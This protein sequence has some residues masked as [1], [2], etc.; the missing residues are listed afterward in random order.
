MRKRLILAVAA[1]ALLAAG[2]AQAHVTL[3]PREAPADSF[4]RLNV[5]VPNE[6]DR[7]STEKV[8]LQFPPGFLAISYE[9]VDGWEIDVKTRKLDQPAELFGERVTEEVDEVSLTAQDGE[10]IRPG[11]FRDFGLSLRIPDTPNRT[12]TFKALQTYS[13]GE[14][15]RWIGPPDSDEPAPQVRLIAAPEQAGSAQASSAAPAAAV[16]EDDDPS[17]ALVIVALALGGLGVLAGLAGL[18][19]ARR[20]RG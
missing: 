3:Q 9:P 16:T 11:Q 8:R 19:T 17:M 4:A 12:L 10:A 6:R 20:A 15:V 1:G 13:N 7:A 14:V 18:L 5:R 2:P